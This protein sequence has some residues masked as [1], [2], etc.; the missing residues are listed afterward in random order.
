VGDRRYLQIKY[1]TMKNKNIP[2]FD[3]MIKALELDMKQSEVIN[4]KYE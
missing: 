3:E 1:N 2:T 4:I